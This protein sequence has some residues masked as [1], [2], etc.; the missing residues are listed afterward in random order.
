MLEHTFRS[1]Q[2]VCGMRWD[3]NG[4][5]SSSLDFAKQNSTEAWSHN[6]KRKLALGYLSSDVNE[7]RKRCCVNASQ[8]DYV[9]ICTKN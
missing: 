6:G 7:Q 1:L 2:E 4:L 3:G 5:D 8:T 9:K